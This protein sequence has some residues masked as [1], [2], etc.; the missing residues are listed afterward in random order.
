MKSLT[1]PAPGTPRPTAGG[2]VRRRT[3]K[4]PANQGTWTAGG[5]MMSALGTV[6]ILGAALCGPAALA[7]TLADSGPAQAAPTVD[8]SQ[9]IA[10]ADLAGETGRQ[11]VTAWLSASRTDATALT[12]LVPG[13][14]LLSS[15][16]PETPATFTNVEVAETSLDNGVWVVLIGADVQEPIAETPVVWRRYF[17][18]PVA[19]TGG[20]PRTVQALALPAPDPGPAR[21]QSQNTTYPVQVA[22]RDQRMATMQ[23]FLEA[24]LTGTGSV[25]RFT[26]PGVLILSVDPAPYTQITLRSVLLAREGQSDPETPRDG[27]RVH[28]RVLAEATRLDGQSVPIETF[29]TLTA[30]AGRWEV[31]EQGASPQVRTS[32]EQSPS[33]S[34]ATPTSTGDQ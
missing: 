2:K 14:Q 6:A 12:Q 11:V 19:V 25:E 33:Q 18:V 4:P 22:A 23:G 9:G 8:P 17:T 15:S 28:A 31:A 27:E 16:L 20:E 24:Q 5:R 13:A 30:R 1:R 34:P 21:S 3:K 29:V 26:T 10:E 32:T 7:V